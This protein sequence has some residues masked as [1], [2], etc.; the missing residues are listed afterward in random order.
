MV[1]IL[2]RPETEKQNMTKNTRTILAATFAADGT[3]TQEQADAAL[4]VLEGRSGPVGV[5]AVVRTKEAARL[6]GGVTTKTLRAWAARGRIGPVYGADKCR[7]GY[8][9]ES[10]K[11]LIEGRRA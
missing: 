4:K 2:P 7:I 3:I 8:T 6:L 9:A 10:V 1:A 11:A 5:G